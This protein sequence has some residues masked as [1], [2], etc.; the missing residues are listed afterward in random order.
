MIR[1]GGNIMNEYLMNGWRPSPSL[2]SSIEIS[3]TIPLLACFGVGVNDAVDW[4]MGGGG[5]NRELICLVV[6]WLG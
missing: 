3:V 2:E 1:K 4:K 6:A 5:E